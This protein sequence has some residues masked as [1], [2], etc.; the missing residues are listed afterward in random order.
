M[1]DSPFL[2]N[3]RVADNPRTGLGSASLCPSP[4]RSIAAAKQ[5]TQVPADSPPPPLVPA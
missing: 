5:F 4:Y 3:L 2:A 1:S